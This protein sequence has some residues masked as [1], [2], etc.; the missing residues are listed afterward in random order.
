MRNWLASVRWHDVQNT[1]SQAIPALAVMQVVGR[2]TSEA[3]LVFTVGK[4][5]A[6]LE[7]DPQPG[8]VLINGPTQIAKSG[9]VAARGAGTQQWPALVQVSGSLAVGDEVGPVEDSWAMTA[10][11]SGFIV[12]SLGNVHQ[13][14]TAYVSP[15]TAGISGIALATTAGSTS[16]ASSGE[17]V[18]GTAGIHFWSGS[19]PAT[20][21][22]MASGGGGDLT[23]TFWN[24]H[25]VSIPDATL[26]ILGMTGSG[27]LLISAVNYCPE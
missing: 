14:S 1:E 2:S 11:G 23:V 22:T 6:S 7:A 9:T 26:V 18:S 25:N 24:P 13:L 19:S 8:L 3:G 4:P 27:W 16:A 12:V 21:D 20:I 17:V 5:D 15:K 10:D